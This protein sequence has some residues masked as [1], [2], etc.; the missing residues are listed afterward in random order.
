PRVWRSPIV[1]VVI[2]AQ[3]MN[4]FRFIVRIL[5]TFVSVNVEFGCRALLFLNNALSILPVNLCIYCVVYLQIIIIHKVSPNKRWPRAIALTLAT[6]LSVGP[7][8]AF[9]VVS[10]H[11][12]GADSMCHLPRITNKELYVFIVCTVSIWVYLPGVIGI[13]SI[14]TIGIHILR[15]RRETQQA[16]NTSRQ[17]YGS[18]QVAGEQ[19]G[20]DMLHRTMVHI[21]WF[22]ITPILSLWLNV[23]LI[24][25]AYYKQRTYTWLEYINSVMLGLQSVLLGI[26][27]VV[28]PTVRAALARHAKKR[29]QRKSEKAALRVQETPSTTECRLPPIHPCSSLPDDTFDHSSISEL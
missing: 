8:F 13:V 15:T 14:T 7:T 19:Y 29:R 2:V 20:T 3:L 23:I 22:P 5:A 24:S 11:K 16:L 18:P 27:L 10:P 26:A 21:V 17:Y 9:M 1:R 25:V 6:L 12:L 4:C 28:N